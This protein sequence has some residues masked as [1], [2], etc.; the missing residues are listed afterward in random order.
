MRG[1]EAGKVKT[2]FKARQS[3]GE[4]WSRSKDLLHSD[5]LTHP[6]VVG[7]LRETVGMIFMI[8]TSL[9]PGAQGWGEAVVG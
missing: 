2:G 1:E 8:F 6:I 5:S 4:K 3:E 7:I 9:G